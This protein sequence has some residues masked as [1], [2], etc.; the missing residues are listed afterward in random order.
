MS[1]RG[2]TKE[3]VEGHET[4]AAKAFDAFIQVMII[5]SLVS[6][7]IETLPNL[8]DL[9]NRVLGIIEVVTVIVFTAEYLTRLLVADNKVRFVFS[10]YGIIDLL[11]ILPFYV[12]RGIDLR[13]VRV[14][15]LLRLARALKMFRY[16]RAVDRLR[17][18]F[19]SVRDELMLFVVLALFMLFVS[20]VGI[21]YFENPEQPERFS[22]V[23]ACL[24]WAIATFTT[25]GYGDVYPV[26]V[27]GKIFTSVMLLIGI[28]AVAIPTG[29]IS[30]ALTK[31]L[32]DEDGCDQ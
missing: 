1:I 12:A 29:L 22:S 25:V 17:N 24:W 16:G 10:F 5:I 19:A 13:A 7:S 26:T 4:P 30:S 11:A 15:R 21:Y 23:F 2:T 18:A 20:S 27:G 6:F 9:A 14:F 8:S 32:R 28:G 3:I 31:T